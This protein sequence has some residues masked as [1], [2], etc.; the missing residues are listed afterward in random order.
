[1]NNF[2]FSDSPLPRRRVTPRTLA[3][4]GAIGWAVAGLALLYFGFLK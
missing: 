4:V 3:I 2:P 1:M